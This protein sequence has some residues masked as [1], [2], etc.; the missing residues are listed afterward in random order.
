MSA[1]FLSLSFWPGDWID[2][3]LVQ[4]LLEIILVSLNTAMYSHAIIMSYG[5]L[6]PVRV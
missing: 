2:E 1:V 5:A 3:A 6:W 4:I